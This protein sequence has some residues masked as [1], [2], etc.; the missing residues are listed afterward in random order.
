MQDEEEANDLLE[1]ISP[2]EDFEDQ[3]DDLE[4]NDDD[5][6]DDG[7]YEENYGVD[8]EL[9]NPR[10]MQN[11]EQEDP[12]PRPWVRWRRLK[13]R[14]GRILRKFRVRARFRIPIPARQ[15]PR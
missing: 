12:A 2:D 6:D 1:M 11:D 15:G 10:E 4:D 14:V 9:E 7:N 5:D 8:D 13:R 3:N